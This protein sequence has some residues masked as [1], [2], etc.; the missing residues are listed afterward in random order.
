MK[1]LLVALALAA[2]CGSQPDPNTRA[3]HDVEAATRAVDRALGIS[4]A[5]VTAG[6]VNV[7][8]TPEILAGAVENRLL[9]EAAGCV[10]ETRSG[11][12][13]HADFT[14]CALATASMH[15]GGS[16]DVAVTAAARGGVDITATLA[17][18]VDGG[19]LTGNFVIS[20]VNGDAFTY[21]GTLSLDGTA[22]AVPLVNAGIAGGGAT[23]DA[24]NATAN[25]VALTL[26]AVHQRFA[27]CYPDDGAATL[28]ALGVS[29]ANAT[30][31]SGGVTLAGGGSDTLPVRAGCP[32]K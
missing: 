24:S 1:R 7:G 30:P 12:T 28:G 5:L 11:A 31:Q 9:S 18:T 8:A 26:T 13:L 29:F 2:G 4:T 16:V 32:P 23:M 21:A 27:G 15:V 10:A 6:N 3:L 19:T 20:T 14:H 22:V 25:G 17:V